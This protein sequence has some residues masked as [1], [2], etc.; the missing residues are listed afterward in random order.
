MSPDYKTM[1]F[2][3]STKV[4]DTIETLDKVSRE[5]QLTQIETE[6]MYIASYDEDET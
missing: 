4:A 2:K 5:S 1:Y 6:E 3:L